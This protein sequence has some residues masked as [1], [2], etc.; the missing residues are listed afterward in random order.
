MGE[1]QPP[2]RRERKKAAT[3][4]A[5]AAAALRLCSEHGLDQ[6][7]V[8]QIADAADVAPRTF[9]N[10]FTSKEEAIVAG[11]A[12]AASTLVAAFT[13][14]PSGEPVAESLRHALRAVVTDPGYLD[15]VRLLRAL[16]GHPTVVAHQLAAFAAQERAL[17]AAVVDRTG[18]DPA[19]DLFPTL[20]A[21][22]AVTGLR[23]AVQHWLGDH[24]TDPR[25][26][27]LVGLVDEVMAVFDRGLRT[28]DPV[29]AA[30]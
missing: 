6:V 29:P 14:R 24:G 18:I 23:V 8:E 5:L 22:A 20:A 10:Y 7:T 16:S 26:P 12:A 28:V 3:R 21:A 11:N 9:F 1:P 30:V 2:G 17:A 4:A 13:T 25:A 27:E 19:R 15:R